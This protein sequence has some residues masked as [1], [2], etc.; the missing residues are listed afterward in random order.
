MAG[1]PSIVGRIGP[2]DHVGEI[3]LLTGAPHGAEVK[4][5][6]NAVIL[7]LRSETLRPLRAAP[8]DLL[9]AF[10]AAAKLGQTYLE[11]SVAASVGVSA[12][13]APNLMSRI[14]SYF[15]VH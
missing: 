15:A 12:N 7:E 2:G 9:H 11:R 10:G 4:A 13:S 1:V 3:V 14:R 6:T 5:L 8:P